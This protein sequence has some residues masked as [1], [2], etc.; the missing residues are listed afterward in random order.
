MVAAILQIKVVTRIV[1]MSA[2]KE[3]KS[4]IQVVAFAVITMEA[5][6]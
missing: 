1:A 4:D 6:M 5:L 2:A 3:G